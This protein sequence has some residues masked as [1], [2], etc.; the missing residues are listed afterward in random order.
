MKKSRPMSGSSSFAMA[1]YQVGLFHHC[2]EIHFTDARK[3]SFVK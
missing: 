2:C 3:I 1:H